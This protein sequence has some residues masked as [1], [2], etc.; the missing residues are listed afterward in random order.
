MSERLPSPETHELLTTS[1]EIRAERPQAAEHSRA[2]R[3]EQLERAQAAVAE[4]T[5]A[6]NAVERSAL[7]QLEPVDDRP[8][9]IDNVAK[10]LRMRKSLSHIQNRLKP[11]EKSFSKVV[12][13]PLVRRVSETTAQNIT[14]PSGLLGGGVTAFIGSLVYL[15]LTRT[16]NVAYNYFVFLLL[17]VGG[18]LLGVAIEWLLFLARKRR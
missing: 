8:Q 16:A 11:A 10:M 4:A 9:L 13:Q 18:F 15:W 7:A 1:P 14:R 17:F 6:A 3:A 12:H 2:E 5:S